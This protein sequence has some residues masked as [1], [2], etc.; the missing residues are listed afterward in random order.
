[1][2]VV[3]PLE[4]TP[5][6]DHFMQNLRIL[7]SAFSVEV[8]SWVSIKFAMLKSSCLYLADDVGGETIK[9]ILIT[10]TQGLL[11]NI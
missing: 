10:Y 8:F 7:F 1:M 2:Q 11:C 4:Q 5:D 9:A 3:P 6:R